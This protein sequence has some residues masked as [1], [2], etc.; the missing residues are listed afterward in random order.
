MKDTVPN[1][2]WEPVE[3]QLLRREAEKRNKHFKMGNVYLSEFLLHFSTW[4]NKILVLLLVPNTN[5][6]CIF[7]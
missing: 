5:G 6:Y 2:L 4:R 7:Q 1:V 3:A